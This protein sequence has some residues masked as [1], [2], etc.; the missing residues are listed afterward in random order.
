MMHVA[1]T[2]CLA[3]FALT[4]PSNYKYLKGHESFIPEINY[5]ARQVPYRIFSVYIHCTNVDQTSTSNSDMGLDE[6]G[7]CKEIN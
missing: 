2:V 3:I 6:T 7:S 5:V 1:Y 4:E